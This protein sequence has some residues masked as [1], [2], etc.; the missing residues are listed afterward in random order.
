MTA[1]FNTIDLTTLALKAGEGRRLETEVTLEDVEMGGQ[2]YSF[3]AAVPVRLDISRTAT[4]HALKLN[5][6]ATLEGTC[7]RCLEPASIPVDVDAREVHQPT[8]DDEELT[9]PYVVDSELDVGTWAHDALV[10]AL[11]QT[12]LCRP[13]CAG[14]CPEC[15][16]P[17]NGVDPA[18]HGHDNPPD[19]RWAKL[20]EL[21]D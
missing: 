12:L 8:A 13:D 14:L 11:P 16:V 3:R 15:G 17:L 21:L 1:P 19:P 9:S 6:S 2:T 5:L 7:M 18:E 10:L 4:G 20:R